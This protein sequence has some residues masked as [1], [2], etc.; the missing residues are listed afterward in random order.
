VQPVNRTFRPIVSTSHAIDHAQ[1]MDMRPSVPPDT[2]FLF[3]VLVLL[4]DGLHWLLLHKTSH[5]PRMRGWRFWARRG[6]NFTRRWRRRSTN[7]I[8]RGDLYRTA[9]PRGGSVSL[10]A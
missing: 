9:G 5:R 3:L 4:M 2:F 1:A 8:Q 7:V 10:C 6:S